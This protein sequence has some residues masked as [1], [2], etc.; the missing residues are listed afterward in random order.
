[1]RTERLIARAYDERLPLNHNYLGTEH[2]I[3]AIAQE[4]DGDVPLLLAACAVRPDD[5][6]RETYELLGHA[7]LAAEV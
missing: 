6:R 3:L 5:I 2:I 4:T 1:M 7:D